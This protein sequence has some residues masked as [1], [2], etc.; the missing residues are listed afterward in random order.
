MRV[1]L[2]PASRRVENR[3]ALLKPYIE[4][5]F[6][7]RALTTLLTTLGLILAALAATPAQAA[8]PVVGGHNAALN[9]G[10]VSLWSSVGI[11]VAHNRCGGTLINSRWVLT[12]AHCS[13]VILAGQASVRVGATD[14]ADGSDY[15][16]AGVDATYVH[17]D[18]DP[19]LLEHD[20]MLVKLHTAVPASVET[21]VAYTTVSPPVG[22][23]G[24]IYGWGWVCETPD[25][26]G[27]RVNTTVLQ[28]LSL[29]V[30]AD[31]ACASEWFPATELCLGTSN[32]AH[33]SACFGDSGTGFLTKGF[34]DTWILRGIMIYDGDDW[35]GSSCANTPDG[36][37]GL[38]VATD[39]Y[40]H[41]EWITQTMYELAA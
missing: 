10:V 15:F 8:P 23:N 2:L 3:G 37:P 12:A 28:Q 22:T 21:P 38:G 24:S 36:G 33:A 4:E 35:N 31:T 5:Q 13:E 16:E 27:C 14:V 30:K 41:H 34:E 40:A 29:Q 7:R 32:G 25:T 18:Y 1:D 9:P 26:P 11:P 19:D 6:V 39:V 20:I 17:P